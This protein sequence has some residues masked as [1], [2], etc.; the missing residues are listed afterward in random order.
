[1]AAVIEAIPVADKRI[2]ARLGE[3]V[4]DEMAGLALT[5]GVPV[6]DRLAALAEMWR[7]DP[8]IR[9][10]ADEIAREIAKERRQQRYDR[11][12]SP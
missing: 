7:T 6:S 4:A 3:A 1:M 10:R 11:N 9:T 8:E 12:R 2:T 5:E